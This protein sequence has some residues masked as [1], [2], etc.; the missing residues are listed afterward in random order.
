MNVVI[1][2]YLPMKSTVHM[3]IGAVLRETFFYNKWCVL[4]M[5]PSFTAQGV[6]KL[7]YL[8]VARQNIS[9]KGFSDFCMSSYAFLKAASWR[10]LA[11]VHMLHTVLVFFV[12]ISDS[13]SR[14]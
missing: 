1:H 10:C 2:R 12:F 13:F 7:E 6:M 3:L 14:I 5:P 9:V 11:Y 4:A 8:D